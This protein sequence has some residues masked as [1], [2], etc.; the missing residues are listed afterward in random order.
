MPQALALTATGKLYVTN[1]GSDNVTVVNT[2]NGQTIATI[3]VRDQPFG[4]TLS[5]DQSLAYVAN[6]DATVSVI[7]TASST[8][9]TGTLRVETS[10]GSMVA[11]SPDGKTLYVTNSGGNTV[12]SA[13]LIH[14]DPPPSN[15]GTAT[16]AVTDN[17]TG[18]T[19]SAPNSN[20]WSYHL[21]A[22]GATGELNAYTDWP[23]NASL[24]GNGNLVITAIKEKV[25]VPGNGTYDYSSAWLTTEDKLEF[26][27]GTVSARIKL[28]AEQGLLSGF[29]MLGSDTETVGWPLGGEIDVIEQANTG[30]FAGSTIHGPGGYALSAP[31]P[32]PIDGA[33]HVYSVHWEPNKITTSIDGVTIATYTPDS[34][35]PGTPWT[36]NDR[37]MYVILSLAVG[38]P[39]G[40]PDGTTELPAQMV[41]DWVKYTPLT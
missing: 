7:A 20:I 24:D 41:V 34:L 13:T 4:I 18:T 26:T 11:V 27:Y 21:G 8:K 5:K 22:G 39:Y 25:T 9:L 1:S 6:S 12:R 31:V 37:S 32:S 28:P 36:F 33:Y 30:Q 23:R 40:Q 17:F 38:S 15:P 2:N 3:A 29:W 19:G 35:P 14:V 16:S 10:T